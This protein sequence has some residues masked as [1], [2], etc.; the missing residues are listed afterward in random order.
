MILFHDI[1]TNQMPLLM[2]G[3]EFPP[4]HS[5][6]LGVA[7]RNIALS[8][9]RRGVP[10]CF[11]LPHF[12]HSQWRKKGG[13]E[14]E[15]EVASQNMNIEIA[16]ISS[17]IVTPYATVEGYSEW[18]RE[19]GPTESMLY[20]KNLFA[21][22]DRFSEE[23]ARMAEKRS[24]N[25]VH[26]HDWITF[27]SAIRVKEKQGTPFV[28]HV[29]ATE[30]DRTGWNPN[31]EIYRR[32]R[33]G[34]ERADRILAVSRH[35]KN[36]IQKDYGIPEHKIG[37]V[38]NGAESVHHRLEYVSPRF[39]HQKTILFLGRLTVQ[40]GPDWLIKIAKK[41]L[42]K[43]QNVQFLI[44]GTGHMLPQLLHEITTSGLSQHVIPLGFLNDSEREKA[45]KN[46]DL[47][48]MPSVS[49]PFG[50][51]AIEAAQR[52]I[53]VIMSKQS[54]AKEVLSNS[55]LADFWD[56]DKMAHLVL[57][58]LHY[59]PLHQTLSEK[60]HGEIKHLTW[61]R[62]AEKICHEYKALTSAF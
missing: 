23:V 32:E 17:S 11:A 45:F 25:L 50:L 51:S 49:E 35:T 57:A 58:A 28:A 30:L 36:V 60:A 47:Y 44:A 20:G 54:G 38:H 4:L 27:P 13:I 21:E 22:I 26:A 15:F 3:W 10:V 18:V 2:L 53:P 52:G 37:V 16:R 24:F 1:K 9:S 40:K 55:L 8:L 62:Q 39:R 46:T 34:M 41:V 33:A 42:E 43:D 59:H 56:V 48:I 14:H 5:G 61:D 12:V 31:E 29:H 19:M 6:G 7:T